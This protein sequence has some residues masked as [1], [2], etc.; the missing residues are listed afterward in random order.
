MR[1][2]LLSGIVRRC[3]RVLDCFL[4][5]VV[6]LVMRNIMMKGKMFSRG[7]LM[8]LKIGVLLKI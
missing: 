5:N 1:L 7:V 2:F 6:M 4:C 3:L 8:W